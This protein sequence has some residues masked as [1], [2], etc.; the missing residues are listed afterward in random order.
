VLKLLSNNA[1]LLKN[2]KNTCKV[3]CIFSH[4]LANIL[5]SAGLM[6]T[7]LTSFSIFSRSKRPFYAV[8]ASHF[9]LGLFQGGLNSYSSFD[10]S[11]QAKKI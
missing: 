5:P 1:L 6:N 3:F 2:S 7:S 8:C 9:S 4:F 11:L 10:S